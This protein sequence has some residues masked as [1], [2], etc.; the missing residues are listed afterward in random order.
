MGTEPQVT[1]ESKD[2]SGILIQVPDQYL[3]DDAARNT[4]TPP[5]SNGRYIIAFILNMLAW[6]SFSLQK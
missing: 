6:I 3:P 4:Q 5:P 1:D 2:S